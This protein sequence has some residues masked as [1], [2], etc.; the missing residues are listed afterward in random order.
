MLL[1]KETNTSLY[2]RTILFIYEYF[3]G[4]SGGPLVCDVGN[5]WLLVGIASWVR[6][7]TCSPQDP[8]VYTRM[9]TFGE[10]AASVMQQY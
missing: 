8:N 1:F 3:Q 4:D 7:E 10:W 2:L 9:S 6:S 5:K